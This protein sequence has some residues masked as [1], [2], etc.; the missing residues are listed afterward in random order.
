MKLRLLPDL[1]SRLK[2]PPYEGCGCLIDRPSLVSKIIPSFPIKLTPGKNYEQFFQKLFEQYSGKKIAD[3]IRALY[4][5]KSEAENLSKTALRTKSKKDYK[6]IDEAVTISYLY[7]SKAYKSLGDHKAAEFYK[8]IH[9][10]LHRIFFE[11]III[12]GQRLSL[13]RK[14][15]KVAEEVGGKTNLKYVVRKLLQERKNMLYIALEHIAK[16]SVE[17]R[18]PNLTE[19]RIKSGL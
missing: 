19:T 5:F 17:I 12:K 7:L 15:E 16:H 14:L 6:E 1:F 8:E 2:E 3:F 13:S 9:R 11:E 10:V 4:R 18:F